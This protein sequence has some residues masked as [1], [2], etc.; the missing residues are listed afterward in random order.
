MVVVVVVDDGVWQSVD[1]T[2]PGCGPTVLS[3][4]QWITTRRPRRLQRLWVAAN[5]DTHT[6]NHLLVTMVEST[7]RERSSVPGAILK[8][9]HGGPIVDAMISG[10]QTVLTDT[11][12]VL[13]LGTRR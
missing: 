7:G 4:P 2:A 13:S 11:D 12:W 6:N 8:P 5:D 10:H 3:L 9:K 1:A